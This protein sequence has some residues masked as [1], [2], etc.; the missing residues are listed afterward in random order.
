M[1]K[2]DVFFTYITMDDVN[3]NSFLH[4][5]RL[6]FDFFFPSKFFM[7]YYF[8]HVFDA[9]NDKCWSLDLRKPKDEWSWEQDIP[10]LPMKLSNFI[11]EYVK[12]TKKIYII[13]GIVGST[14]YKHVS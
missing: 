10:K 4:Q 7:N 13:G 5:L 12:Q 11:M 8:C 3:L 14:L 1:H 9:G 2:G 6:I